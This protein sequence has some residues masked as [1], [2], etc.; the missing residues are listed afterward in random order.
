MIPSCKSVKCETK[1]NQCH[2]ARV[3]V[4]SNH[5]G[6]MHTGERIIYTRGL[7]E[8]TVV[9]SPLS[10]ARV[11]SLTFWAFCFLFVCYK[12]D[13]IRYF[14][15]MYCWSFHRAWNRL[16]FFP[17]LRNDVALF[18]SLYWI[19]SDCAYVLFRIFWLHIMI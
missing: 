7:V 4:L 5:I 11:I 16:S 1:I 3:I 9:L 17:L 18:W 19:A 2:D 14:N 10:F 6:N 13:T 15:K 12:T 8:K